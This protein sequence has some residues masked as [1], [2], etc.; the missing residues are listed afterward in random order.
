MVAHEHMNIQEVS[1]SRDYEI[2]VERK[3][4]RR[5]CGGGCT[6]LDKLMKQQPYLLPKQKK[7]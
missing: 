6:S 2:Y 7:V 4:L 3:K 1:T 5:R